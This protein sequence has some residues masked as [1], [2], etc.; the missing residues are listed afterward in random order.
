VVPFF[1]SYARPA[2][3]APGTGHFIREPEQLCPGTFLF[4]CREDLRVAVEERQMGGPCLVVVPGEVAVNRE[5][6]E[7]FCSMILTGPSGSPIAQDFDQMRE[8]LSQALLQLIQESGRLNNYLQIIFLFCLI[9]NHNLR[10]SCAELREFGSVYSYLDQSQQSQPS[11]R[12]SGSVIWISL[13]S[14]TLISTY[15]IRL[16]LFFQT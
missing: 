5:S 7:K 12:K 6:T 8:F 9:R 4:W 2:D 11:L 13:S 10:V 14:K 1:L 3:T 16:S 15:G